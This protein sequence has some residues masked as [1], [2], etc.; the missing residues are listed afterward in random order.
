MADYQLNIKLNGV[1]QAVSSVGDMEKALEQTN[2][3]LSKIDKNS[4]GFSELNKQSKTIESQFTS[5]TKS[6]ETLGKS[7]NDVTGSVKNLGTT[8]T[9]GGTIAQQLNAGGTSAKKLST[10]I[11]D[12]V[13]KSMSLRLEL[14]KIT[15]ELQGLEPGSARFQELSLRAGQLRDTIADTSGV[16]GSLT[17]T[18]VERLGKALSTTAQIGVAG[19]QG[20]AAAS[21]LFGGENEEVQKTLVKLTALLNLSQA[22]TTFGGL[23]DKVTELKAGFLS[24]FPAAASSATAITATA[25]ATEG[26]AIASGEAAVATTGFAVALNALP[27]VAI[28][29]ALGLVVAGLISYAS[30]EGDAEKAKAKRLAA[31]KAQIEED[32]KSRQQIAGQSAEFILQI[33]TLAATNKGSSERKKLIKEIN[34]TYNT[35]LQNLSDEKQFQKQLNLEVANYIAYQKARFKLDKNQKAVE[36]NLEKQSELEAKILKTKKDRAFW[37]NKVAELSKLQDPLGLQDAI[38]NQNSYNLKIADF[39]KE[40]DEANVRLNQYGKVNLNVGEIIKE[41]EGETGKYVEGLDKTKKGLGDA[42]TATDFYAEALKSLSEFQQSADDQELKLAQSRIERTETKLDDLEFEKDITLAKIIVEYTAQKKAI[43]DNITDEKKRAQLLKDLEI[44]RGRAVSAVNTKTFEDYQETNKKRVE[45]Y[46]KTLDEL[47]FAEQILAGEIT[48]GNNN[49]SDSLNALALRRIQVDIDFLE[50]SI[51][52]NKLSLS[53]FEDFQKTKETL[54]NQ[55]NQKQK[56]ISQEQAESER[57]LQI[58]EIVKFY[59]NKKELD[60]EFDETTKK[61]T[62]KVNQDNLK[63]VLLQNKLLVDAKYASMKKTPELEKEIQAEIDKL[64]KEANDSLIKQAE[65]TQKVINKQSLNL[66]EEKN[67]KVLEAEVKFRTAE[68]DIAKEAN[69]QIKFFSD[70]RLARFSEILALAEKFA[71]GLSEINDLANQN[72]DQAQTAR[73]EAFISGEQAKADALQAAYD[74]DIAANN[75]TEDEKKAKQKA[76]ADAITKIQEDSNKAIDKSNRELANNQFKRQ[77]ALNIVNAVISGAQAVLSA[78]SQFG[79]PPSP[80]G[81]AGI[82]AAGIITAAQI[83]A[84]SKQKFDGGSTGAPTSV[85]TPTIPDTT[86]ASSSP[87]S[88]ASSG[89]FTGFNEGLLGSPGEGAGATGTLLNNGSQRVYILE[90]DITSTQKRVETLESNASFG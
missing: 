5:T 12:T 32:K 39:Q 34:D 14:R 57:K 41:I 84:I 87:I 89:G 48:F 75:Y 31:T 44:A 23:G 7:I 38:A 11:N 21:A 81:I 71:Q 54:L 46:K 62:V 9:T 59:D 8:I 72:E 26:E 58:G 65:D 80:A 67:V 60:V 76:T 53:D 17:G 25:V 85:T 61:S 1:E 45:D 63:D 10:D 27:L 90:S 78:I 35:T 2:E 47:K 79:P 36:Q 29:T 74:A 86:S 33:K 22:L 77:K 18:G 30:A 19:F 24:L 51:K 40:I 73:N 50:S 43:E 4:K 3:E 88:S 52:N 15:Q 68:V 82:V 13:T 64:N 55:A 49:V 28:V 6:A 56:E 42:K 37:D 83:A 69:D 20:I 70:E 66:V 16:I